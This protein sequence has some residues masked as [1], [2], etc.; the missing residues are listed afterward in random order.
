M[1]AANAVIPPVVGDP[2][3]VNY[4]SLLHFDGANG[5]TTFTDQSGKVW[6]RGGNTVI[7]TAISKF[8]GASAFFDGSGDYIDTPDNDDFEF[9]NGDFTIEAWVYMTIIAGDYRM[10][11]TKDSTVSTRG[12]IFLCNPVTQGGAFQLY[13]QDGVTQ[14]SILS[15]TIP[16][17]NTMY[18]VAV[19]RQG[20][21]V[22][23]F[24]N[25]VLEAT[26]SCG[27]ATINPTTHVVR[28]GKTAN[29]TGN[30]A[31]YID[32]VRITKGQAIYTASFTPA[33]AAFPNG[34][35]VSL[36][37][38]DGANG[39]TTFTDQKLNTWTPNGNA[40]LST[41][42][43]IFGSAS[44]LFD[45]TG[46]YVTTPNSSSFQINA[47]YTIECW[48][49]PDI[50]NSLRMIIGKR[51]GGSNDDWAWYINGSGKLSFQAWDSSGVSLVV[52]LVGATVVTI[53]VNHHAAVAR[54]GT[55]WYLFLDGVL[56]A[57]FTETALPRIGNAIV[58]I[59]RDSVSTVRDFDGT[60]D[61]LRV[62]KGV[63][64]YTANFAPPTA[65]FPNS[66]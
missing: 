34:R 17:I 25:G 31:G 32:E 29:N 39:S 42:T 36:L 53:G 18:H 23:M 3:W 58:T 11:V 49:R 30:F 52:T 10:I 57:T 45:G 38:F 14:Y 35:T 9:G 33:V 41:A 6:T 48:I 5:S 15:T 65:A 4:S 19:S 51:A 47:D 43:P 20:S 13:F 60:I 50:N 61:E 26:I 1:L 63:A 55:N 59:G 54:Q 21:S 16:V 40:Q 7:S 28:I 46:D 27:T 62:T 44:G 56:D 66:L 8:G 12:F 22:R 24:V 37:H 64:R 2:Y